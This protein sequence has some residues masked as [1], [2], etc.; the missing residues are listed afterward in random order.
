MIFQVFHAVTDEKLQSMGPLRRVCALAGFTLTAHSMG[1]V[2]RAFDPDRN[3]H[4]G[5]PEFIAMTLFL[6]GCKAA[7]K[8]FDP[9]GTNEVRFNFD[10]FLYAAANAR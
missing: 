5:L 1:A 4:L 2:M 6:K 3:L 7:F 8:A 9:R 10:Q